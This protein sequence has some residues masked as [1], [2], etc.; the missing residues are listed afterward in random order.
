MDDDRKDWD[1]AW[2]GMTHRQLVDVSNYDFTGRFKLGDV[3]LVR[4]TVNEAPKE[5]TK[6]LYI[7][8]EI[9]P[10]CGGLTQDSDRICISVNTTFTEISNLG[11][12]SWAH[13]ACLESC[14]IISDPT[15]I[16]W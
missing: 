13:P 11:F 9:C 2:S 8:D 1:T 4:V 3:N 12:S 7:E 10:I 6:N 16:P 14:P 15:P 5:F